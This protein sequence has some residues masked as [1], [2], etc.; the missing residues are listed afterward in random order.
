M[1]G[2]LLIAFLFDRFGRFDLAS[3]T[4][5]SALVIGFAITIKWE[6]R[7]HLWFWITLT[8]IVV[9]HILLILLV[10]WT[11]KWIPALVVTPFCIADLVVILT[12]IK[13]VEKLVGP[14]RSASL[15]DPPTK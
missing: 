13:L 8:V 6:L 12:I 2:T 10:P 14:P 4:L 15:V 9:L 7:R 3:P 11:T 5:F 1:V